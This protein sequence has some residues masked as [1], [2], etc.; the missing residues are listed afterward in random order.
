MQYRTPNHDRP[1]VR[2]SDPNDGDLSALLE[3]RNRELAAISTAI[4]TISR[5]SDLALVLQRIA[6]AVRELMQSRYAALGVADESG[7]L[8]QFI[9][10]GLSPEERAAIGPLPEGHGLLGALIR[11]GTPLRIPVIR[12]DPRSSGFPPN[13]PPMTSLLGV[14]IVLHG[15]T[16]GDLYLTD[17]IGADEFGEDDQA[18]LMLFAGHAAVAIENARLYDEVRAARDELQARN[19]ELE[20]QYREVQ[21][22]NR[23]KSQFLANMSHELRTPLN[24]IIGFSELMYEGRVGPVSAEHRE[25]LGDILTS[26]RHLLQIINDILDLAKVESGKID[27][28][29]EAVVLET[30]VGEVRDILRSLAADKRLHLATEVDATLTEIRTDPARLKQVLYNFLSNAIKFTPDGGT[31]NVRL[32]PEG[33]DFFRLAVEDTGIGIA[34]EDLDRLFVEFQQLDAGAGKRYQGTGLG[35][36]LTRR[37]AET[38][39]GYVEV[40]SVLGKGSI[41]SAVLPRRLSPKNVQALAAGV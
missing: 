3:R 27:M 20:E 29:P 7:R 35:L 10:S 38:E 39:G 13:H 4:A 21:T 1:S 5:A 36:A 16:V 40:S 15:K 14:P 8:V 12:E 19:R 37:I 24:A 33:P 26:G 25:Y 28:H 6:D 23:L 30:L 18:L 17:K 32:T 2:A 11:E 22:A 9:T 31:V 41:F 34:P